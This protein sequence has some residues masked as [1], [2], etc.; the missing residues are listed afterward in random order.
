MTFDED[1]AGVQEVKAAPLH[2]LLRF[3]TGLGGDDG[4]VAAGRRG[5]A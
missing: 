5:V 4:D 2:V 3:R 1:G